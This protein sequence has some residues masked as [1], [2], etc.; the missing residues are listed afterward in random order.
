M[1]TIHYITSAAFKFLLDHTGRNKAL[2]D[3]LFLAVVLC[4]LTACAIIMSAFPKNK[5]GGLK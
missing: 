3:A 4:V 1:T 2:D 5:N